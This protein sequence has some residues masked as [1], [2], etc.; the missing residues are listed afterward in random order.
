MLKLYYEIP[1]LC[2]IFFSVQLFQSP[3]NTHT[4]PADC[5]CLLCQ[6]KKLA[7]EVIFLSLKSMS[8]NAFAGIKYKFKTNYHISY[9]YEQ[10]FVYFLRYLLWI[11]FKVS[12]LLSFSTSFFLFFYTMFSFF[13]VVLFSFMALFILC[14]EINF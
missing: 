13:R 2:S 6:N 1:Y 12:F 5:F 8:W 3:F 4:L 14:C 7:N 11:L 9:K 10:L